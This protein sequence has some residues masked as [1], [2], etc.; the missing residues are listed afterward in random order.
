MGRE[1][2]V[3]NQTNIDGNSAHFYCESD[4]RVPRCRRF[5]TVL[6]TVA[7]AHVIL[8][9]PGNAMKTSRQHYRVRERRFPSSKDAFRTD[10]RKRR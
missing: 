5:I 1:E 7:L 6:S 2:N 3:M 10:L 8:T 4:A 9:C